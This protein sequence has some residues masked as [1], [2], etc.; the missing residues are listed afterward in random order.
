MQTINLNR[1]WRFGPGQADHLKR[2]TGEA[3]E[4][5]VNRPHD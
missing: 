2:L 5:T 3:D 4:R 1:G